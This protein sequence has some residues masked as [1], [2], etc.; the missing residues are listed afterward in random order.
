MKSAS[1]QVPEPKTS[2]HIYPRGIVFRV[3]H[4]DVKQVNLVF[5][6]GN[7]VLGICA[8]SPWMIEEFC[9]TAKRE[10]RSIVIYM[11]MNSLNGWEV[12]LDCE[13]RGKEHCYLYV[14][15]FLE[16]LR[17]SAWLRTERKC[18]SMISL[19]MIFASLFQGSC[20]LSNFSGSRVTPEKA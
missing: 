14:H 3:V 6:I 16:W 19:W 17:S 20:S 7:E 5:C 12:L 11:C 13:E 10:E 2:C 9:L 1:V 8:R 18:T 15:E 4:P